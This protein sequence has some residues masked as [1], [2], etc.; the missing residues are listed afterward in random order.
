[1]E[2]CFRAK[3]IFS[4]IDCELLLHA[5]L[6]KLKGSLYLTPRVHFYSS[7]KK[8]QEDLTGKS[9]KHCMFKLTLQ[10]GL[11]DQNLVRKKRTLISNLILSHIINFQKHRNSRQFQYKEGL[12]VFEAWFCVFVLCTRC[13]VCIVQSAYLKNLELTKKA[14]ISNPD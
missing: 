10:I 12:Y 11:Y 9:F 14:L 7:K 6:T 1:M 2:W 3:K 5:N 13:A 8:F 4:K